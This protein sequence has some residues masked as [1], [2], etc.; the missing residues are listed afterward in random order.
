MLIVSGTIAFRPDRLE[1]VRRE[2]ANMMAATTQE[3]GCITYEFS[4]TLSNP[5]VYRLFEQWE[6]ADAL[7]AHLGTP[8]FAAFSGAMRGLVTAAPVINRYSVSEIGP[9]G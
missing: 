8:H 5:A 7:R 1:D 6:D 4:A 9:V 2:L 3:A